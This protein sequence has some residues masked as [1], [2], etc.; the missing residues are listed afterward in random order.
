MTNTGTTP[1]LSLASRGGGG[2]KQSLATASSP[3]SEVGGDDGWRL[4]ERIPPRA[5]KRDIYTATTTQSSPAGEMKTSS[6]L[7]RRRAKPA[8]LI[9]R[10]VVARRHLPEHRLCSHSDLILGRSVVK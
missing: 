8:E 3:R 9:Q 1:N 4:S 10:A 2:Q 5:K 7:R 6:S